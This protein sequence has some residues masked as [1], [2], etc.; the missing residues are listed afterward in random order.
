LNEQ[1]TLLDFSNSRRY[2]QVQ[3]PEN[4]VWGYIIDLT[5]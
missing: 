4:E 1:I 3:H 2:G 5:C